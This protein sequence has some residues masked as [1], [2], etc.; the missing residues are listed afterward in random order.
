MFYR[1]YKRGH[2]VQ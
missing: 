1:S 2:T